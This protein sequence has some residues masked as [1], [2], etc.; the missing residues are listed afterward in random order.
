ME[1]VRLPDDLSVDALK[2]VGGLEEFEGV[3]LLA[4]DVVEGA[5]EVGELGADSLL[6]VEEVA[7]VVDSRCE[8]YLI[9]RFEG[10]VDPGLESLFWREETS[11][12]L[13]VLVRAQRSASRAQR[14]GKDPAIF[15]L[16]GV[17]L[18]IGGGEV[19]L[20][21]SGLFVVSLVV[22][23]VDRLVI[24]VLGSG[25]ENPARTGMVKATLIRLVGR[26]RGG[27]IRVVGFLHLL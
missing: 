18:R 8:G 24:A 26:G 27:G 17:D 9:F 4:G 6:F 19:I 12:V 11:L 20:D 23:D 14:V 22:D 25:V 21:V 2:C 5:L 16:R 7:V 1:V 3:G 10:F 15:A 13:G